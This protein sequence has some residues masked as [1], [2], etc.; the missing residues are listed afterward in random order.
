METRRKFLAKSLLTL[1]AATVGTKALFAEENIL[2]KGSKLRIQ[3]NDVILFQGD[4]IT[5]AGRKRDNLTPNDTGAFG[6]GYARMAA[7]TLLN[8]YADKNIKVYTRGIS[9]DTVPHVSGRWDTDA[10]ALGP[11]ILTILIGVNDFWRTIDSG[12]RNTPQQYKRHYQQLFETTL[13]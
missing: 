10:L 2:T 13:N 1:G 8:K 5:D 4:S 11:T 3:Q 9:A 7:A 12:A 6:N